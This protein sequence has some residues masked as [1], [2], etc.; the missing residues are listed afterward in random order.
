MYFNACSEKTLSFRG[1]VKLKSIYFVLIIL[2]E[3]SWI[4]DVFQ[5][6]IPWCIFLDSIELFHLPFQASWLILQVSSL[7]EE[8]TKVC[9]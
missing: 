6:V 8:A 3:L 5:F 7:G 1:E 9:V 4:K 2:I